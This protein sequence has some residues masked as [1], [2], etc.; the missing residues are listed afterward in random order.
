MRASIFGAI[1]SLKDD[2]V[3]QPRPRISICIPH[4]QSLDLMK[5]CLRSIRKHSQKYDLQVIVVDNGSRDESLDYLR[6]LDWILLIERPGESQANWPPN[7]FSALDTGFRHAK[8]DYFVSMH[9]DTFVKRDGWLDPFLRE[10]DRNP[11]VAA[12][13]GWKLTVENPLYALQKRVLG[14]ATYRVKRLLGGRK[15]HIHWKQGH[16]PRDYCAVYRRDAVRKHKLT[17]KLVN[18]WSGGGESIAEQIRAAGHALAIIP[19]RE[20]DKYLAH[21]A[22]G[23]AATKVGKPLTHRSGQAKLEK[24]MANLFREQWV[25]DLLN[26]STLDGH[27]A[28][29]ESLAA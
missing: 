24:R 9:A 23:T 29:E 7:F 16:Y 25:L 13:G 5:V 27:A 21:V 20:L 22:H 11:N 8:G 10:F 2:A 18:G 19:I 17:F 28:I 4:W 14:Y 6:G 1:R 3:S 15:R 26:D 12:A